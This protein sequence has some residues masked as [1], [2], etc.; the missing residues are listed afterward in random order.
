[1]SNLNTAVVLKKNNLKLTDSRKEILAV[2]QS[3]GQALSHTEIEKS[4]PSPMDRITVYRTLQSFM[5]KGLIHVVTDP[6]SRAAKYLFNNPG[7]PE[8]HAHF[9]CRQCNV[10]ICLG[11]PIPVVNGTELP[12]GYKGEIYSLIIEGLCDQCKK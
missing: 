8:Q 10:L 2:L 5:K 4:L 9:K 1:M 11:T 6:H 7:L 12:G 3:S